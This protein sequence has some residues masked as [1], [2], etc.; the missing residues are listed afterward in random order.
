VMMVLAGMG[1]TRAQL[2]PLDGYH[3]EIVGP[4][5]KFSSL[6]AYCV[7]LT[8]ATGSNSFA[9]LL[10]SANPTNANSIVT[11]AAGS[12]DPIGVVVESGIAHGSLVW[13]AVSGMAPLLL[14]NVARSGSIITVSPGT[15]GR[16]ETNSMAGVTEHWKEIGHSVGTGTNPV[17][18]LHFN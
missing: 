10:V 4:R 17:I 13:V 3:Y 1:C 2:V 14:S 11:T 12:V 16:G 15:P 9:G 5:F 6:G 18:V 7:A 8:N